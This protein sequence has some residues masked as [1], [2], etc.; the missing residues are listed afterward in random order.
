MA[1]GF[2]PKHQETYILKDLTESQFLVLAFE[3]AQKMNWKIGYLNQNGLIAYT[4]VG[5]FSKNSDIMIKIENDTANLTSTSTGTGMM[6]GG[7]N[8][9]FIKEFISNLEQLKSSSKNEELDRKYKFLKENFVSDQEDLVN[10]PSETITDKFNNILGIL[11]PKEGFFITPIIIDLNI[12]VFILMVLSGVNVML[13]DN[14]SLLN[15]G[16]NFRPLTLDGQPWRIITSCFFVSISIIGCDKNSFQ[17]MNI[18][19]ITVACEYS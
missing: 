1:I 14:D 12:I 9:H 13:P 15:W 2:P 6:D 3:T 10:L 16:A 11:I 4:E 7:K 18:N 5:K 8:K 19:S 17:F